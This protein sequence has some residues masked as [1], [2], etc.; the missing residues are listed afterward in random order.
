MQKILQVVLQNVQNLQQSIVALQYSVDIAQS[1]Y[2][3]NKT[4]YSLQE[5]DV[6][7]AF[8]ARLARTSDILV[9]KVLKSVQMYESEPVGTIRDLL[10][11]SE[12]KGIILS[13]DI[14]FEIRIFRNEIAHDYLPKSQNEI[15]NSCLYYAPLLIRNAATAINYIEINYKLI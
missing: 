15:I 9:Q 13:S 14:L 5:G 11:Q 12:K 10:L 1:V 6:F 3:K 4:E 2:S 7:E 8:S